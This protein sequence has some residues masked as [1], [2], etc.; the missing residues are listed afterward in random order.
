MRLDLIEAPTAP[1]PTSTIAHVAGSSNLTQM[2]PS[3]EAGAA[4]LNV[5][6]DPSVGSGEDP[7]S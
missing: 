2:Y 6:H 7:L 1:K 4:M 5:G 3:T